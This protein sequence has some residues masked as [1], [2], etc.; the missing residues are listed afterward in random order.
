MLIK[1]ISLFFAFI[2]VLAIFG[3]FRFP[4]QD[5]LAA[6]K[7]KRCGRYRIGNGPCRCERG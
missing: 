2:A 3:K 7:C 6:A 4:G 1:I 5:R